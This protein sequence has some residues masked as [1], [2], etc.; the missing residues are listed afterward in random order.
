VNIDL[1]I[2]TSDYRRKNLD[3]TVYSVFPSTGTLE[4]RFGWA[5]HTK[6]GD[7]KTDDCVVNT[8]LS[9]ANGVVIKSSPSNEC[10]QSV[11]PYSYQ[12][13]LE[14][15]T[16]VVEVELNHPSGESITETKQI[17]IEAA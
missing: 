14:P 5:S 17:T 4:F 6:D 12:E 13:F 1:E 16:Y 15:G 2:L 8:K 10:S 3:G 7:L 11:G 9:R